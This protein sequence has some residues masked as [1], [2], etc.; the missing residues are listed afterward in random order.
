ML[1]ISLLILIL[2]ITVA[3]LFDY[4]NGFNDT[5]NAIATC[6]S[7]RALT[8]KSAIIMAAVLNFVGAMISTKV[9]TTIGKGIVDAQ[10][11]TQMVIL[12]GVSSAIIWGLTTWFF[13]DSVL[14]I[15]CDYRWHYRRKFSPCRFSIFT[16][17]WHSQYHFIFNSF[18]SIWR[19]FRFIVH[20]GTTL[21]ISKRRAFASQQSISQI[22]DIIL[23][24]YGTFSWYC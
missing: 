14:V 13:C 8:I 12:A 4:I 1:E 6:V 10:D 9:A 23:C 16:L 18:S 21:G 24:R 7:T 11:I 2:V 5:A 19:N 22:T 15:A 17:G 3:L 20:D